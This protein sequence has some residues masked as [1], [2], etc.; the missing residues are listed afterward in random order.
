MSENK[1]LCKCQ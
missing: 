1:V